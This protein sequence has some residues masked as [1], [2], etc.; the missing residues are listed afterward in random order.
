M[1]DIMFVV[2]SKK[3]AVLWIESSN[4]SWYNVRMQAKL[5]TL[6]DLCVSSLRGAMLILSPFL[7]L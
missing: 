4:I 3:R 1:Y 2:F 7:R 6:L 5:L